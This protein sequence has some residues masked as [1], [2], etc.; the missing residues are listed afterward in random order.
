MTCAPAPCRECPFRR[1]SVPGWLGGTE[2]GAA[3]D[4]AAVAHSDQDLNCHMHLHR[5]CTGLAVYRRNVA[6]KPR[7]GPALAAV[8]AV[9]PDRESVFTSPIEFIQHHDTDANRRLWPQSAAAPTGFR[10]TN[11]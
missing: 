4:Y 1:A 2:I 8:D 5:S 3:R 6:K 7:G 9:S 11:S 10:E